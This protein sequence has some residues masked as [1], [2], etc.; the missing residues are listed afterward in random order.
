LGGTEGDPLILILHPQ[1]MFE[2]K[3]FEMEQHTEHSTLHNVE[4]GKLNVY[5]KTLSLFLSCL[6]KEGRPLVSLSV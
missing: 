2:K 5:M 6:L 3:F 4:N 1:E